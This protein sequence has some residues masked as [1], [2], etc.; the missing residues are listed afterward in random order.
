MY[1]DSYGYIDN[2]KIL[3]DH[4]QSMTRPVLY[5]LFVRV[6]MD[7][8]LKASIVSYLLN[9]A[10]LFYL[11]KTTTG[12]R[13]LFSTQNTIVLICVLMLTG[14]WSYCG[15]YLT[16]SI[17]F[18]VELWIFILLV[19]I[20]FPVSKISSSIIIAYSLL[21][22]LLAATL[23]P[24][25][26]VAVLMISALLLLASI[27]LSSFKQKRRPALLFFL[28][29]IILFIA[30]LGYNR[31]KS[32]EKANLVVFMAG[33][34]YEERLAQRL[35]E[36]GGPN[37][38]SSRFIADVLTDIRLINTKFG[39]DPFRAVQ[40]TE[41][42]VLNFQDK[43]N[44]PNIDR[45]FHVMY[46]EH[47]H[48][49]FGLVGLAFERYISR[50]RLGTSCFEIAYGPELPGIRKLG[51]VFI[52]VLLGFAIFRWPRHDKPLAIFTGIMLLVGVLYGLLLSLPVADELQRTVLPAPL[53]E[54]LALVY[55]L[56]RVKDRGATGLSTS[57]P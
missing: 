1:P 30:G 24:W 52:I 10:S 43:N 57:Q 54:V 14:I 38:E 55:T 40:T 53:F 20:L 13:P 25:I 16:E 42:K 18:A 44:A 49:A 19:K 31:S 27:I 21:I 29:S 15:T 46:M 26:M 23:K 51:F 4:A 28:V 47:F 22:C 17:L 50:L 32:F 11:L 12:K 48:D 3:F 36:G 33:S 34:G 41:L 56:F 37:N 45:A 35:A 9:C 8:H 39:R 6:T 2:S 7:L 5:P